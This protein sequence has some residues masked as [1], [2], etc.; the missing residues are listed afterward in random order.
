MIYH[1]NDAAREAIDKILVDIAAIECTLGKDSTEEE[2]LVAKEKKAK[3]HEDIKAIDSEFFDI[4]NGNEDQKRTP[5]VLE[6]V[7]KMFGDENPAKPLDKGFAKWV[8][9]ILG[10]KKDGEE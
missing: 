8:R 10:I 5:D 9:K 6:F 4:I 1:E 3:L 7:K 2:K